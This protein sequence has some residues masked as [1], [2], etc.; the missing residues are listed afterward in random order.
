MCCYEIRNSALENVKKFGP[1]DEEWWEQEGDP[2]DHHLQDVIGQYLG[3]ED[4]IVS[5]LEEGDPADLRDGEI[6]FYDST[7]DYVPVKIRPYAYVA[8][9]NHVSED[10]K[11][12]RRFFSSAAADLFSRVF[13]DVET[14][15]SRNRRDSEDDERVIFEM[16][17][18]P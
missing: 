3:F 9:W 15:K 10:L 7:Q 12:R 17:G 18:C 8:D 14:R 1:D 4:E 13:E 6:A 16:P 2:L 5:A 11:H